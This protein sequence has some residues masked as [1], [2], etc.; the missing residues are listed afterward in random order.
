MLNGFGPWTKKEE[1]SGELESERAGIEKTKK[2]GKNNQTNNSTANLVCD[3]MCG[4]SR[5]HPPRVLRQWLLWCSSGG[6]GRAVD[7]QS[8]AAEDE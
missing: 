5:Q 4:V 2:R 7:A 3:I 8:T 6:V 1:G